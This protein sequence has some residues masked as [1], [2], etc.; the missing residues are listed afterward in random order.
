M[1]LGAV[2]GLAALVAGC[3]SGIPGNSIASVSGNPIT[4]QA[5]N[6]WMYVAAKGSAAQEPGAPVIVPT[7]PPGFAD[8]LKQ[9]RAQIPALAKTSDKTIKTDCKNLFT[10]ES[11]QVM[12]YL[13]KA[14]W[15]Q[16]LAYK[17]GI[18]PTP[19]AVQK[20]LVAAKKTEFPT[21]AQYAAFLK[22]TGQTNAD[23]VFRVRV[24]KVYAELIKRAETKVDAA[25]ISAYYKSHASDFSTPEMRNLRIVLTKSESQAKAALA[26]LQ[27]GQSWDTVAKQYSVDPSTKDSGGLLS[28]VT[29]GEEERALNSVAFAAPLN[30][31]EG[32]V[33][34]TFGWYVV[35]VVKITP[36]TKQPL[37]KASAEISSVL[38][39]Q[40]QTAAENKVNA[41]AKK[42]YGSQTL[43]RDLYSMA[44]CHG[45]T[46]P[47]TTTTAVS[48][49]TTGAGTSGAGAATSTKTTS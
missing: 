41:Q 10:E 46:A 33:H 21:A 22:E 32:P 3:G 29:N 35:Q 38:K 12:D 17:D 26:A 36:A 15:Y 43:C 18:R 13:I 42:L 44:D 34:G 24:N 47:K 39:S 28:N 7:D 8:C 14:Y 45:Y 20:A 5:F 48:P 31:V 27:S 6:H 23:I 4:T 11:S 19:A 30:K 49:T 40:Q 9:V 16:A 37:S 25:T 2:V 1:A